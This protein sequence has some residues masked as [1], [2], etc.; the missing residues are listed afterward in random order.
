M[1]P[2]TD[3]SS[4][5]ERDA[6]RSPPGR[7]P[8]KPMA[9]RGLPARRRFPGA[10]SPARPAGDRRSADLRGN[11]PAPRAGAGSD[12]GRIPG[13]LSAVAPRAG[14][15]ASVPRPFRSR[16]RRARSFPEAGESLG[17]F[18]LLAELGRGAHGRVFLATQAAL[19]DRPVVLK[20]TPRTG[21]RAPFAG[22]AP[23]HQ[24]PAAAVRPGRRSPRTCS[25]SA[26]PY[27]GGATLAQILDGSPDRRVRSGRQFLERVDAVQALSPAPW[28]G[29]RP[30]AAGSCRGP[31]R[32]KRFAGWAPASPTPSITP[33]SRGWSTWT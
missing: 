11:V 20:L 31:R 29:A 15:A 10:A 27:F 33:T 8:G 18:R 14:D 2:A 30:G 21:Q 6:T 16:G 4:Q 26:M 3:P 17:D 13:S 9:A 5:Q 1:S 12:A 25:F 23:A 22:P 24:H 28:V 32:C 19:A 7:R